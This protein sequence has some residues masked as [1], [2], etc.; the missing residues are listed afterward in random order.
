MKWPADNPYSA[1]KVDLGRE[2]FFDGG[3]SRDSRISCAWCHAPG[4]AFAD[5]HHSPFSG[6]VDGVETRRNTPTLA[7]L[8]WSGRLMYD[9][10][11]GSLEEQAL[12]PLLNPLEMD[13]NRDSI[14]SYLNADSAYVVLFRRAFGKGPATLERVAKALAA[15][16]RTL[17]S[18]RSPYDRWAEG[19]SAAMS[20]AARRGAALFLGERGGCFRCHAPPLFT[21]GGFHDIGLDLTPVD[22][23]RAGVTGLS[24]DLGK[25]KTPTLRNVS[26]TYPYMHD[27]RF[28]DLENIVKHY[29]E[30]GKPS[31]NR[32]FRIVPLGLDEEEIRDIVAFLESLEDPDF[33]EGRSL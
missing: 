26:R 8:G 16:Q 17:V 3:I 20:P 24:A 9:G 21:D 18:H 25:F 27:G 10:I 14:E 4:T 2:L 22:S 11:A 7:N 23:G 32:D 30:G 28:G 1:A 29:N 6:G 5:N 33:I 13:S 15:F 31:P 12:L 19:D